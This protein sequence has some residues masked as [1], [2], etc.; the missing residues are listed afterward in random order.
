M[1]PPDT[2]FSAALL[3]AGV[4]CFMGG[5]IIL[6]TRRSA[7]G[8]VPLMVLMFALSWWDVTYSLFWAAAP[9]PFPNF[10][11]YITYVGVVTV[12]AALLVFAMQLS[13]LDEWLRPAFL[14]GLCVEPILVLLSLFTDPWHGLFF[15]GRQTLDIGMILDA[16]PVYWANIV[17]SYSLVLIS[18]IILVRRFVQSTGIYRSQLGVIL[19]GLGFPWLNSIVFVSGMSP[20]PNADNTPFSFTIAGLAFTY[21]L[22]C[23]R[24]LDI[25][26]IARHT[27]VESMSDGVIVLDTQDRL[28]DINPAAR[29]VM[30]SGRQPRLGERVEEVFSEWADLVA[31]FHNVREIRTEISV[32]EPP[33]SHLDLKISP[34]YNR[35]G[36]FLGR[37]VV[38]R[39]ITPL[40]NAQAELQEQAIRDPLT[41]LYN[42]RYLSE[43]LHRELARADRGNY[44]VSLVMMDIDHFKNLNDTFG[45]NTG[46][47][48][49]LTF[50][51][52]LLAEARVDDTVCRYGGEEFLVVL[53]NISS[54]T[55][56][57]IAERWRKLFQEGHTIGEGKSMEV[58]VSCGIAE[59]PING[60]TCEALVAAA[61]RSLYQAKAMGRNR[62]VM[63]QE[64]AAG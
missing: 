17:Y 15:A 56:Y 43:T 13:S 18:L 10:W 30:G 55:A 5:T 64:Q 61:D 47:E 11:L 37:L 9:A 1:T 24:L 14:I 6:Q 57:E 23:Y 31:A 32:G 36:H 16:G 22:L 2:G 46:D 35:R 7:P 48:V 45:H 8:S 34:L 62:V 52:Q 58:T 51:A 28:V 49:L 33:Q 3:V 40:K 44:P 26:P 59:F 60:N 29:K 38:W 21:A 4:I 27:L 54:A 50:A 42:R 20:F 39:D 53:P 41:G 63:G 12:P 19:V 25:L